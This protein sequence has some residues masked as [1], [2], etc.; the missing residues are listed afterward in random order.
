[1]Y[2]HILSPNTTVCNH[3]NNEQLVQLLCEVITAIDFDL[4]AVRL[5]FIKPTHHAAKK[6]HL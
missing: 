6:A 4:A 5:R 3:V 1:M 2:M